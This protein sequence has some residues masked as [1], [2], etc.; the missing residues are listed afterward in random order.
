MASKVQQK[1][2]QPQ[3]G[4]HST[5]CAMPSSRSRSSLAVGTRTST[6][7]CCFQEVRDPLLLLLLLVVQSHHR[8]QAV[9]GGCC[10]WSRVWTLSMVCLRLL[11]SLR[12]VLPLH[13]RAPLCRGA[14]PPA[15]ARCRGATPPAPVAPRH[16]AVGGPARTCCL[17]CFTLHKHILDAPCQ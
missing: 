15:L 3:S 12:C 1:H 11:M 14:T 9:Q 6:A 2:I 7:S 5:A 13:L 8:E 10:C 17:S 16:C 4:T